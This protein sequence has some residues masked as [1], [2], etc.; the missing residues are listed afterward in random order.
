MTFLTFMLGL[1]SIANATCPTIEQTADSGQLATPSATDVSLINGFIPSGSTN[2]TDCT[3]TKVAKSNGDYYLAV[4]TSSASG[5]ETRVARLILKTSSAT[6]QLG[7]IND[8]ALGLGVANAPAILNIRLVPLANRTEMIFETRLS[9]G[10]TNDSVFVVWDGFVFKPAGPDWRNAETSVSSSE[11][12]RRQQL[13][14]ASLFI[15][16]GVPNESNATEIETGTNIE[17]NYSIPA[18]IYSPWIQLGKGRGYATLSIESSSDDDNLTVTE[19]SGVIT[20]EY[21]IDVPSAPD[22]QALLL[23]ISYPNSNSIP[24]DVK[25][26]FD[27]IVVF[28]KGSGETTERTVRITHSTIN[29][30][31]KF[32]LVYSGPE[33][34]KV[35]YRFRAPICDFN[36]D[37]TINS[38]DITILQSALNSSAT[39]SD[40]RDVDGNGTIEAADVSL[41]QK[42]CAMADCSTAA[43]NVPAKK[44]DYSSSISKTNISQTSVVNRGPRTITNTAVER[45][46]NTS[47][48]TI[49]GPLYVV[50]NIT[51]TTNT[52]TMPGALGGIGILP[53]GKYY[54]D[55]TSSVSG[56]HLLSNQSVDVTLVFVR[57]TTGGAFA[58]SYTLFAPEN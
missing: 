16:E 55:I 13:S 49:E 27:D 6:S 32:R 28:E 52:I 58:Y 31:E 23:T 14:E 53:F 26:Y 11:L 35:R 5:E 4:F 42:Q 17:S 45:I 38:S 46:T 21:A 22:G 51:N 54:L 47:G 36:H 24:T 12:E 3:F 7:E 29:A 57:P 33:G 41:C 48:N 40:D 25:A 50:V 39:S 10:K 15:P 56:G 37:G 2:L 8:A 43:L 1:T 9:D 19:D 20:N 34:K 18:N 44:L 30:S